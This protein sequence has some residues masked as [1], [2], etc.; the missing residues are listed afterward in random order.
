ME[1]LQNLDE[2]NLKEIQTN[3]NVFHVYKLE[4]FINS[5]QSDLQIQYN[6]YQNPNSIFYRNRKKNCV[7]HLEP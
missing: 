6:S 3:G 1:K 7:V 5:T 2:K 4:D